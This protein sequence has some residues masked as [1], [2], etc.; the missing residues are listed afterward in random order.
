MSAVAQGRGDP[1]HHPAGDHSPSDHS[2][3]APDAGAVL[4]KAVVRAAQRLDVKGAALAPIL[5][6]SPASLSR[7]RSGAFRLE[8]GTKPFELAVL[9]VRLFRALDALVGGDERVARA[10]LVAPNLALGAT[11]AEK[12]RTIT[13]LIDVLAYLDAR[14]A[15][16]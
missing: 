16:V 6:L 13:G 5:G 14:R 12:I 10:W 1:R 9:F 8:P 15:I 2:G 3:P 4:S 11:P 7:L